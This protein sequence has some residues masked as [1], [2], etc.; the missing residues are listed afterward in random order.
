MLKKTSASQV[1]K[2]IGRSK[3]KRQLMSVAEVDGRAA[4]SR[5]RAIAKE[6]PRAA[7]CM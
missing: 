3:S 1:E 7:S 5:V 6:Q 4:L 2:P